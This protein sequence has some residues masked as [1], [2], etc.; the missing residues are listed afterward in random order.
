M[1]KVFFSRKLQ[2]VADQFEAEKHL[3]V[4]SSDNLVHMT[5][6]NRADPWAVQMVQIA[7]ESRCKTPGVARGDV[8]AWN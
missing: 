6:D 8:G 3:N 7:A 1:K 2:K 4:A 5:L